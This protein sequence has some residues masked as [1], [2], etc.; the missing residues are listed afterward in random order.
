[1]DLVGEARLNLVARCL[2]DGEAQEALD[3]LKGL[4][5]SIPLQYILKGVVHASLG[6]KL[7]S[8]SLSYYYIQY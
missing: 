7:D 8:V 5:P 1:M 4:Q 3:L 2:K 6:Q